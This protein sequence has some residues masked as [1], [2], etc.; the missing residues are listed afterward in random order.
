MLLD[1][2]KVLQTAINAFKQDALFL[3]FVPKIAKSVRIDSLLVTWY[4]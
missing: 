3:I 1:T 2:T 4:S